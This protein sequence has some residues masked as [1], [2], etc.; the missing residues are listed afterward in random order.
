[1]SLSSVKTWHATIWMGGDY[2]DAVRCCRFYC[3]AHPLCVTVMPV[4][5]CYHAGMED[6]VC[7]RLINYPRFPESEE[8][9]LAKATHLADTLRVELCQ[10]SYSIECPDKTHYYGEAAPR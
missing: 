2:N 6:G 7:I 5:F 1:M 4:A 8:A 3:T 9:I 10:K